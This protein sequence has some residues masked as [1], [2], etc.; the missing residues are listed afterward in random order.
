MRQKG[1]SL[2]EIWGEAT[3]TK[4]RIGERNKF[5]ADDPR[6]NK[7]VAPPGKLHV[8]R[9]SYS[10]LLQKKKKTTTTSKQETHTTKRGGRERD[11]ER[12]GNGDVCS[13]SVTSCQ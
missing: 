12:D 7:Q 3:Q 2:M 1:V 10:P 4:N 13:F 11:R 8:Q 6:P 9:M 5:L